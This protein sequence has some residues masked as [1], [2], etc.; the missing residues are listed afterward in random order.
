MHIHHKAFKSHA[1]DYIVEFFVQSVGKQQRW[2]YFAFAEARRA[3][4]GGDD[5]ES[6]AHALACDLHEA[7]FA[8]RQYVVACT[9]VGHH[10]AHVF[11]ERLPVLGFVHVDEVDHDDAAHVAQA[12]LAGYFVG[13][14]EVD[15]Q[16]VVLLVC[17]GFCAVAGVY[18]DN[19]QRFGVLDDDVCSRL[20]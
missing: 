3:G 12:Q 15:L 14:P 17:A 7:E 13:G 19:V 5:V 11:V 4:F 18:V 6:R 1:V 10:F 9:V 16:G 20:E 8:Q 2:L